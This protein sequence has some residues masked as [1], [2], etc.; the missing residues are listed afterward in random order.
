MARP[1][2]LSVPAPTADV[3]LAMQPQRYRK[4]R[5]R[6]SQSSGQFADLLP[7]WSSGDE[8]PATSGILVEGAGDSMTTSIPARVACS[9]AG[10]KWCFPFGATTPCLH[11]RCVE[12]PRLVPCVVRAIKEARGVPTMALSRILRVAKF[13]AV[14]PAACSFCPD[15]HAPG[16][17]CH[18][19]GS[20]GHDRRHG[21][22][23]DLK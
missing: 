8:S 1:A 11:L 12:I 17:C 23:R 16:K 7:A 19:A 9:T 13:E 5:E 2:P 10:V 14:L 18:L 22:T 21:S 4:S 6:T 3:Y 20:R 15:G